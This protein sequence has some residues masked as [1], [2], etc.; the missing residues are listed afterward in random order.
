MGAKQLF[1]QP[2]FIFPGASDSEPLK[3]FIDRVEPL[4]PFRIR[5]QYF[6]RWLPA[7]DPSK[8]QGRYLRLDANWRRGSIH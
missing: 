5:N 8:K 2:N 3:D 1:L 4:L 6:K 7:A